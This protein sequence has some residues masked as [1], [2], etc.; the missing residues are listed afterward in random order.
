MKQ[1]TKEQIAI[2]ARMGVSEAA[3]VGARMAQ[4]DPDDPFDPA[5]DSRGLDSAVDVD[6]NLQDAS[7]AISRAN[8]E[9]DP[10]LRH[11]H[12]T[13]AKTALDA[14]HQLSAEKAQSRAV[15]Y[16]MK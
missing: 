7:D 13:A 8:S 2:A 14:A 16:R 6:Q 1:T 11:A 4:D 9:D 10:V 3:F 15:H 12:I 5:L